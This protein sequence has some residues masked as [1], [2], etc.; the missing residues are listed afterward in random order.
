M[1]HYTGQVTHAI[2]PDI[3]AER[4][5]L[6]NDFETAGMVRTVYEI[7][8]VGPTLNGRNGEG[9]LYRTDGEIR[10]LVLAENGERHIGP[11]EVLDSPLFVEVK[12]AIWDA[13]VPD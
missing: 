1:S 4:D 11:P 3:D 9:N 13:V 8:G 5:F 12:D 2:A 10:M 6:A 7:S